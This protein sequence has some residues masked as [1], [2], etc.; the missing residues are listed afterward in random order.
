MTRTLE[1]ES[2]ET[3]VLHDIA[4]VGTE[5]Q[6][7]LLLDYRNHILEEAALKVMKDA[8]LNGN[9]KTFDLAY[10]IRQLKS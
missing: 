7:R 2:L 4:S 6:I 8:D 10:D 1:F 9:R 3:K 5:K